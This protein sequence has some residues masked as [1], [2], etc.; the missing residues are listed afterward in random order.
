MT[1]FKPC[2]ARGYKDYGEAEDLYLLHILKSIQWETDNKLTK[3]AEWKHCS[4][5]MYT[6][7]PSFLYDNLGHKINSL[8]K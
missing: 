5:I 8:A 1:E 4:A 6:S 3:R 7:N 2:E